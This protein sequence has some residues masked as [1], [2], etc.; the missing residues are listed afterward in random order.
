MMRTVMR[1]LKSVVG[2]AIFSIGLSCLALPVSAQVATQPVDEA[3]LVQLYDLYLSK[4]KS[5]AYLE[6]RISEEVRKVRKQVDAEL[7][8]MLSTQ[9]DE[10]V[11]D[12]SA[13]PRALDRQRSVVDSLEESISE[14]NV[15]MDLLEEEEKKYYLNSAAGTGTSL[16]DLRITASY[17]ELLAK[18]AI[19]EQRIASVDSA[20][21]LQRDRLEK[22]ANEQRFQQ[23]GTFFDALWYLVIIVLALGLD[24]LAKHLFVGKLERGKH[25]YVASKAFTATIYGIA[26]FWIINRLLS[27][28]PGAFASLAIVGAA[29]ALALQSIVKDIVGWLI[30][31]QRRYYA[32]GDRISIGQFTGD[33]IDIGP[34]R[35]A[36]LEVS[37]A[38]HPNATERTGKMLYFPNSLILSQELLNY[39]ATSDFVNAELKV[40]VTHDSDW[41]KAE[42]IL[43]TL[44]AEETK[45]FAEKARAQQKKRTAL[46][47]LS[48]KVGE[49]EVHLDA[50]EN[51]FQFTLGF[52]VPIGF[53]RDLVTRM[54][55]SMLDKFQETG[56]IHIAF[57]TVR[58]IDKK[59]S[60]PLA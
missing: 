39:H 13:L 31:I 51:G 16:D 4:G 28:H 53:R 5:D 38:L 7:K 12:P 40:T 25:R 17:G 33:V 1:V 41:R 58:I 18:K 15:D 50:V 44:L 54:W 36:L 10:I 52:I 45:E 56:T 8:A 19:L 47:Y 60:P 43:K 29:I 23:F 49:P 35:T 6:K 27:E 48:R 32:P 46:F 11:T 37:S 22:L 20:L 9:S 26:L 2:I 30:I 34:L 57:N 21:S 24:R 3:R 55:H 59:A 42:E 14:H